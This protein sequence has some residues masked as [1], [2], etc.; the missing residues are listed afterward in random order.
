MTFQDKSA[1]SLWIA[2]GIIFFHTAVSAEQTWPDFSA[3]V[4]QQVDGKV[5]QSKMFASN[6]KVRMETQGQVMIIRGDLN[7]SWMLM[8]QNM[9]MEQDLSLIDSIGSVAKVSGELERVSEGHEKID[10]QD[11]EKFRVT[12]DT[13]QGP[14]VIYQWMRSDGLPVKMMAEDGSWSTEYRNVKKESPPADYFELPAGYQ[15]MDMGV[16]MKDIAAAMESLKGE[17]GS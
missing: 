7:V 15:K 5:T 4:V 9:Y 11:T 12:S 13:P 6:D 16:N 3:D 17:M 2:F 10:G 1:F 8:P 14:K